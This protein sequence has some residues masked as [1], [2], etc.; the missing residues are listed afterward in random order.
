[1]NSPWQNLEYIGKGVCLGFL[2]LLAL[3]NPDWVRTG[4]FML[5][6]LGGLLLALVGPAL[7]TLRQGQKVRGRAVAFILFLLLENPLHVY[8]GVLVGMVAGAAAQLFVFDAWAPLEALLGVGAGAAAGVLFMLV[9]RLNNRWLR[10]GTVLA[11]AAA[12]AGGFLWAIEVYPWILGQSSQDLF[13][14]HVFLAIPVLYLLTLAGRTMET[15]L[16][17]G[18]IS[19]ALGLALWMLLPGQMRLFAVFLPVAVY[20][21]YT[22]RVLKGLQVFKQVLRGL[23]YRNL[24]KY[25][26][27]LICYRNAMR[28]DPGNRLAREGMWALHREIDFDQIVND[29]ELL[30]LI[31][32]DLCVERARELLVKPRPA[33][34]TL[35]EAQKLLTLVLNQRPLMQPIVGYWRAVAYTHAKEFDAAEQE[36]RHILTASNYPPNDAYRQ[37][38]LVPAWQLALL[39]HPELK[40]RLGDPLLAQPGKRLEAIRDAVRTLAADASD[41]D[42]KLLRQ[43]LYEE[44]TEAE[45][46]AAAG[47]A[48]HLPA[49]DFDHAYALSVGLTLFADPERWRRGAEFMR[50][51]AR[52]LPDKSLSIYFQIAQ[53]CQ[54][55][56]DEEG[57]RRHYEMVKLLGR[58]I[59]LDNLNAE[60]KKAYFATV[61]YLAESAYAAEDYDR[62]IDNFV[63][64][65]E[66][67]Q[68]GIDTVRL[69]TELFERKGDVVSALIYNERGLMF[70]GSNKL[71]LE[72]KDR[73]YYSLSPEQAETNR[74]RLKKRFDVEYCLKKAKSLVDLK[75]AGPEQFDWAWHLARLVLV[76]EPDNIRALSVLARIALRLGNEEEAIPYLERVRLA[77]PERFASREE[78][79]S[80]YQA[81]G[82]LGDLYLNRLGKPDQALLCFSD[83]RKFSK[84][85]ADT[86]YKMGQAYE[87][88]GDRIKAAKCY[89]NVTVYDHP[90]ASDAYLALQR[91]ESEGTSAA[92]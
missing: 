24:G 8:A 21:V 52:G 77:K 51:A 4:M 11:A 55:H 34:E 48:G 2:G 58:E 61:K 57:A 89:Q 92:P 63:L 70:D 54:R 32:L 19:V 39:S 26:E 74:D 86:L 18:T 90:L 33:P 9:V 50:I 79:E 47:P 31:D 28:I 67:D 42:A 10:T 56:G 68:S 60:D 65:T 16:E 80:W 41:E 13:A 37:A 36:L 3:V 17:I 84:S 49:E 46:R 82:R 20:L 62:A 7:R 43:H 6:V 27:A 91:L 5:L 64:Y 23:S 85:G 30:Q 81:T 71:L 25:R 1:M 87:Q 14:S 59:G 66:S 40:K 88:L 22:Q 69:L 44:L 78:E 73:Y 15:E 12:V 29:A 38:A 76:F 72:R 53:A 75:N 45:Y 83:Y 35:T